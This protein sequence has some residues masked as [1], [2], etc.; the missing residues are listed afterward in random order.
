MNVKLNSSKDINCL[1][2][3]L[4]ITME[5]TNELIIGMTVH[6]LI[7][8]TATLANLLVLVTVWRNSCL[9]SPSTTLLLSLALSDLSVGVIAEPVYIGL[10]VVRFKNDLSSCTLM[11]VNVIMSTFLVG[12]TLFTLTAISVDR[13]SA[14]Y[15]HLRYQEVVTDRRV[16]IVVVSL[17]IAS[18]LQSLAWM[19]GIHAFMSLSL[20]SGVVCLVIISIVWIKTYQVV[21]HHQVQIQEQFHAQGTQQ[22]NMARFKKTAISTLIILLAA[23]L[24][25]LPYFISVIFMAVDLT[26]YNYM[27]V[28]FTYIFVL[29]NSSLNPLIYCW[30]RRDIGAAAKQTLISLCCRA[31]VE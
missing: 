31:E 26:N 13:Y 3:P 29:L 18:A 23:L 4:D 22:F 17:W 2:I 25:Y 15:L 9:H 5:D 21:R 24:C 8:I 28:Q 1:G 19:Y 7:S 30:R 11:N 12:V 6:S 10:K 27:V 14:I 20:S 16:K